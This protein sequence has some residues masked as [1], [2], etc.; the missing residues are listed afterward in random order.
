MAELEIS[1]R[2]V[3]NREN[4][5]PEDAFKSTTADRSSTAGVCW[6]RREPKGI[7]R[8]TVKLCLHRDEFGV[9][10]DVTGGRDDDG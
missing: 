9:K 6:W 8:T 7:D 3:S 5:R 10:G 4:Q 2:G 1:E